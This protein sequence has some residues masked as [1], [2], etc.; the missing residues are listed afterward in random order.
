MTSAKPPS[1]FP[2]RSIAEGRGTQRLKSFMKGK[3]YFNNRRSSVDCVIRD[4]TAKGMRLE[5][6][7]SVTIPEVVELYI[8]NKDHNVHGL[9]RWRKEDQLGI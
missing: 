2:T 3:L 7:R 6:S 8:P 4:F 9:V 1:D 5:L